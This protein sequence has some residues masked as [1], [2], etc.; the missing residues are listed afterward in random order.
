MFD[1]VHRLHL[2]EDSVLLGL[3]CLTLDGDLGLIPLF[4]CVPR[5]EVFI[6]FLLIHLLNVRGPSLLLLD[7]F[8]FLE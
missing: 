8:A 5:V 2:W 6:V 7:A 4:V 1:G 3:L